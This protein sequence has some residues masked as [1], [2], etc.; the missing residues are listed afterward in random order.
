MAARVETEQSNKK[1]EREWLVFVFSKLNQTKGN[2]LTNWK[3]SEARTWP[4]IELSHK[5]WPLK[6]WKKKFV[7]ILLLDELLHSFFVFLVFLFFF[8]H[9][10]FCFVCVSELFFGQWFT[11]PHLSVWDDWA[12]WYQKGGS[13][14][15]LVYFPIFFILFVNPH[16][17]TFPMFNHH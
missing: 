7:F 15:F 12:E 6:S 16:Y 13:W 17:P 5:F 9:S 3:K 8:L 4:L 2:K 14:N 10:L 11:P 1:R